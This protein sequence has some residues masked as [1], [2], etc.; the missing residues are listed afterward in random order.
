MAFNEWIM[1]IRLSVCPD[2]IAHPFFS[3]A[4]NFCGLCSPAPPSLLPPTQSL[5]PRFHLWQ[6]A[7]SNP[8]GMPARKPS[9]LPKDLISLFPQIQFLSHIPSSTVKHPWLP[10]LVDSTDLPS[11]TFL[12][13]LTAFPQISRSAAMPC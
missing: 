9:I 12:F 6:S 10:S 1:K 5:Y 4:H 13:L 3:P 7:P 11:L 2:P 8:K